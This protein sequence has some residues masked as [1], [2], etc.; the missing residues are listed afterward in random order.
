[1]KKVL[2]ALLCAVL[3]L[4]A[5]HAFTV[6]VPASVD[7]KDEAVIR[8]EVINDSS[9]SKELVVYFFAA[10]LRPGD[11]EIKAPFSVG[12]K[13]TG[14]VYVRVSNPSN[15]DEKVISRLEIHLGSDVENRDVAL[16]FSARKKGGETLG[17]GLFA[18][19]GGGLLGAGIGLLV[20]VA[21]I[22]LLVAVVFKVTGKSQVK[23]F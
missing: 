10:G 22:L 15:V 5:A 19:F 2:V 4:G 3:L 7:V 12:P 1:M 16:K 17:A 14:I 8:A 13:S 20:I 21:I 23:Q 9:E 6:R 18:L 11:I